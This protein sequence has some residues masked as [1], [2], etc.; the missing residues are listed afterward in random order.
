MRTEGLQE[1]KVDVL[2]L[3]GEKKD[4]GMKVSLKLAQKAAVP[5]Q[6]VEPAPV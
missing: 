6:G 4:E 2:P 3:Q 1:V 5:A